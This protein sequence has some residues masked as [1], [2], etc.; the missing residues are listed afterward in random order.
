MLACLGRRET[1]QVIRKRLGRGC[2]TAA[3]RRL[4]QPTHWVM[5]SGQHVEVSNRHDVDDR[6]RQQPRRPE[7]TERHSISEPDQ[8]P[9]FSLFSGDAAALEALRT[10]GRSCRSEHLLLTPDGIGNL[11]K[12]KADQW[13]VL[14]VCR[15]LEPQHCTV[16]RPP[17]PVAT[18]MPLA[19][20]NKSTIYG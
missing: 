9:A 7:P 14:A 3:C 15:C 18:T 20:P 19:L 8:P 13:P 11:G 1:A 4:L 10:P 12:G 2:T 6:A 5:P 17:D 16:D